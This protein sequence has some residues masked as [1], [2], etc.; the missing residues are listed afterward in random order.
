MTAYFVKYW[1]SMRA[2]YWFIPS[3]MA[4]ASV[5][6]AFV[7]VAIDKRI[8]ADFLDA[9][10]ILT[11][12]KPQGAR[13][14]LSTIAGSMI[15]VAGVTFSIT[16]AAV[17]YAASQFGPRL[18]TN[19]MRDRGNQITLG[20]FIA[21]FLY[22]LLV[23]RTIRGMDEPVNGTVEAAGA[24]VPHLA[25]VVAMLFA[26]ASIGVLIY[27][28]HHVPESIHA[29][30]VTADIGKDLSR[31]I[32]TVFP[33][34]IGE[35][36]GAGEEYRPD[37]DLPA[38]FFSRARPVTASGSGYIQYIAQDA[39][40]GLAVEHDALIRLQYAPGDFVQKGKT[41]ALVYP[42]DDIDDAHVALVRDTFAW[43]R[44]RTQVQDI[45]F[46]ADEL[47]EI[48]ARALSPGVNDPFTAMTCMDWLGA[49][50]S[51]MARRDD[52][53]PF[54][55]DDDR[56]LRVI[57]RPI[58]FA[59]FADHILDS[60]RPYV[61]ADELTACHALALMAQVMV[62]ADSE[63]DRELLLEHAGAYK[64]AAMARFDH[65]R[66]RSQITERY[67]VIFKLAR[68]PESQRRTVDEHRWLEGSA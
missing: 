47:I 46:L 48:A 6:L 15:T 61:T 59:Y 37:W 53:S 22:C 2:S 19:F 50:L 62:E 41:L 68:N 5:L 4:S 3:L 35:G 34:M 17:A 36:R 66:I 67:E 21:T 54:R 12:S 30:T 13:D 43:G 57:A 63:S 65:A 33:E 27:F 40:L 9:V 39:L 28:I 49:A 51:R 16:I 44:K 26:I 24:F 55:F 1:E 56:K 45:M 42:A 20:T 23:L 8:G 58:S 29:A 52:P 31:K 7:F 32:D 18:L 60:A 64:D 14:V 11:E 10:D 25:I 38:D